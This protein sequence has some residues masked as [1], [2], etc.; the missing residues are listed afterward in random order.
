MSAARASGSGRSV[1]DDAEV[2]V[3]TVTNSTFSYWGA[4]ASNVLHGDNHTQVWAP[5]LHSR[6]VDGGR[7][8]QHDPLWNVLPV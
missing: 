3:F 4:Y 5:D 7:P 8:W 1:A 6:A 2:A